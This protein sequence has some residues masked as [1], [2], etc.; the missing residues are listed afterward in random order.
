[1]DAAA[2]ANLVGLLGGAENCS[3][4]LRAVFSSVALSHS[5]ERVDGP[6][7]FLTPCLAMLAY[8]YSFQHWFHDYYWSL[9]LAALEWHSLASGE[10]GLDHARLIGFLSS[11]MRLIPLVFFLWMIGTLA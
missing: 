8:G 4:A 10:K 5:F 1:M 6:P 3:V 9:G 7:W 2:L 11:R